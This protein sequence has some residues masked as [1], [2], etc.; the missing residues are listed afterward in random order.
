M[1]FGSYP[2]CGGAL[3]LGVPHDAR[4]PQYFSEDCPHCKVKVWHK[5]SRIDPESWTEA[6]FLATHDV[7][8]AAK[9]I[10]HKVLHG[11]RG[12]A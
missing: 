10:T 11:P 2:C 8:E 6:E 5:L 7:D 12:N 9:K 1:I 3:G 4:L